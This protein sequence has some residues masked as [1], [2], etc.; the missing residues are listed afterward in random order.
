MARRNHEMWM[1]GGTRSTVWLAVSVTIFP[2]MRK[3]RRQFAA[4]DDDLK[5]Y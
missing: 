4:M 1:I 5:A 2:L 3:L